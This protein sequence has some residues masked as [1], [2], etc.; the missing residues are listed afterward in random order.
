MKWLQNGNLTKLV[1]FFVIAVVIICTV[2]FAANGWQSFINND[3]DDS[4]ITIDKNE[5][6]NQQTE[7]DSGADIED[8]PV[9]QP[10]PKYYHQITG[11]EATLEA[12]LQK[13]LCICL[14]SSVP[15]Y[16]ISSSYLTIEFPTEYGNTRLLCFTDEAK[17]L[18]KIGSL[19]PSRG[20]I[21]NIATYFGGVLL[22]HGS[23]DKFEYSFENPKSK[24]DFSETS[25][26]CY[27]EYNTFVYTNGDLVNA[28]LNNSNISQTNADKITLPYTFTDATESLAPQ[29]DNAAVISISFSG[30]STTSLNYSI[31]DGKYIFTKDTSIKNDLLNDK[32]VKY[33]NVFILYADST[34]HETESDTQLILDTNTRGSGVYAYGG[35]FI[36]ITWEKDAAGSLIFYNTSGE[37]LTVNR[38]TSYIAF[39][40]A[41]AKAS[42]KLS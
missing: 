27:S 42:V 25:G 16:G 5:S 22:S 21:S 11:L 2:S 3:T 30:S 40:K 8:I 37:I 18:G 31:S 17:T 38:G 32:A 19:A 12:S 20:Y 29:G 26:Y 9:I 34:T 14:D 7:N 4:N 24:L 41:S 15:L 23:D 6:N 39:V 35:K 36:E 13:P 33:D 1:A 10:V 28:F